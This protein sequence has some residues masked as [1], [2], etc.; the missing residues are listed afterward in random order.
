MKKKASYSGIKLYNLS[1]IFLIILLTKYGTNMKRFVHLTGDEKFLELFT[2]FN[3]SAKSTIYIVCKMHTIKKSLIKLCNKL[4]IFAEPFLQNQQSMS[5]LKERNF[6]ESF[7]SV[8]CVRN[9]KYLTFERLC[10][11]K[12]RSV[13]QK[14]KVLEL[15]SQLRVKERVVRVLVKNSYFSLTLVKSPIILFF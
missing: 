8:V 6:G 3:G 7:F 1:D 11:P 4:Q 5:K 13:R 15:R 2:F 10:S 14:L 12:E 9:P